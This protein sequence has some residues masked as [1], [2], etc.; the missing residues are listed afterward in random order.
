MH[1]SDGPED[2]AGLLFD[3]DA[4]SSHWLATE[5]LS[6][7]WGVAEEAAPAEPVSQPGA[8]VAAPEPAPL[9]VAVVTQDL[10][11]QLSKHLRSIGRVNILVAGQTGVGKSTLINGV[12]GED[13]AIAAAGRPVTQRAQW[14]SS[15]AVP[16][17]ILDTKGLE[18]E[19]YAS[20]LTDLKS[21]IES[22]RGQVET[23]DQLHIGWVC[24]STPSS[25][26]QP[27]EVNLV[28]LLNSFDIP[29]VL[30]L[31]KDDED[32]DFPTIVSAVMA[33][34]GARFEAM[35]PVRAI[36]RRSTPAY[37]L[38]ALVHAT[39]SILPQAHKAAFAAAQKVV[40]DLNRNSADEFV[41]AA[42]AA[43]AA[44]SIVP[45]P[46]ADIATLVPIQAGMLVGISTAFNLQMDKRQI[47]QLLTTTM[48]SMAASLAGRWAIG[49]AL[50]FV[51]GVGSVVGA[52]LNATVAAAI[53]RSLGRAY[54]A[55]LYEAIERLGRV[56]TSAE[57]LEA[58]PDH[59]R[60]RKQG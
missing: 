17:R 34:S 47:A 39:Y 19:D 29:V 51:P 16:L 57:I 58:F 21:E 37:G 25:R 26:V 6:R 32:P 8:P 30:V 46:F 14:F 50:K 5:L 55:F 18:A 11:E 60:G 22:C 2:F 15:D 24:I 53:T 33:E 43:A 1:F 54:I 44:A 35:I 9:P 3:K 40:R 45:I 52:A 7:G 59:L 12:F 42:T 27:C 28:K 13:F 4:A 49:S 41:T 48:C 20:T 10:F 56:P 23:S 31:T 38:E 36:A